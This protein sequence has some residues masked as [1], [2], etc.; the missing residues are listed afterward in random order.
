MNCAGCIVA[1]VR[2]LRLVS[3]LASWCVRGGPVT[4]EIE[5]RQ[6][7]PT[8]GGNELHAPARNVMMP[9]ESS[10]ASRQAY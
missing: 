9:M 8:K 6:E 10:G 1:S 5:Q 7:Y 2:L 4:V 3:P